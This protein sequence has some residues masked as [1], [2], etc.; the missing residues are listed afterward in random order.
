MLRGC[1][2]L[3]CCNKLWEMP[4]FCPTS[5][6]IACFCYSWLYSRWWKNVHDGASAP[7]I[8]GL[9][10]FRSQVTKR[11]DW[12]IRL[13][14]YYLILLT[15]LIRPFVLSAS[16]C[17]SFKS[18]SWCHLNLLIWH[19]PW[20]GFPWTCQDLFHLLIL[21]EFSLF[22]QKRN[23]RLRTCILFWKVLLLGWPNREV[24]QH[25]ISWIAVIWFK[26]QN[27]FKYKLCIYSV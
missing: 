5:S 6:T 18:L 12:M 16:R 9:G 1:R 22:G 8:N 3:A 25:W 21:P 13:E 19:V 4:S 2:H 11:L 10:S 15:C 24:Q 23:R 26:I 27:C 17:E 20:F 14:P 7:N